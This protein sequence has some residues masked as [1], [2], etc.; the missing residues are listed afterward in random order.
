[1]GRH[2]RKGPAPKSSPRTDSSAPADA[3]QAAQPGP[4]TAHG[5][6]PGTDAAAYDAYDPGSGP[7]GAYGTGGQPGQ[8]PAGGYG[9]GGRPPVADGY[10]NGGSGYGA[11]AQSGGGRERGG[12]PAARY[13]AGGQPAP[14]YDAGGQPA[15][16]YDAGGQPAA[17]YGVGGQS[18]PGYHRS[19]HHPGDYGTGAHHSAPTGPGAFTT[20]Q[21]GQAGPAAPLGHGAEHTATGYGVPQARGG[22]PEQHEPG[23][24][25]G[26]GPGTAVPPHDPATAVPPHSGAP[27]GPLPRPSGPQAPPGAA[28]TGSRIPGP[29]REFVDAFDPSGAASGPGADSGT[30][31]LQGAEAPGDR[32]RDAAP[33]AVPDQRTPL[34]GTK[35]RT[36]TGIAA[37]AVTTVLAIIVAGQ[38]ATENE[39]REETGTTGDER[40]EDTGPASRSDSRTPPQPAVR[41]TKPQAPTYEQL[42]A[43]RFPIDR[44]FTGSGTFQAVPGFDKAPG[45][46][47]KIPYR[48]DVEKG[49]KMD[50]LLFATAVQR[51]LND[52]R[53]WAGNG[54]MAF[55]R[56]SSGDPAFVITLASPGT[57][58]V[59]C[60]KSGLNTS[61]DKVS[62]DSASTSRVMINAYRWGLGSETY[63]PGAMFAYRQMLINHEVGH[64]LGHGHVSCRTEGALA[65]VMQQQTK[66]L[67]IDDIRCRPNPWVHP[68]G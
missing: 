2:S 34:S 3:G 56:I 43:T 48:V 5:A 10:G 45:K 62:C 21:Q 40:A 8:Q 1:M 33:G 59:W 60:A 39:R 36:V 66:S 26:A 22:H 61:I 14:G 19:A 18:A 64:R 24:G 65:P 41:D 15:P 42:M 38:V 30:A 25:W 13:D 6:G 51:T 68:K 52:R 7:S 4:D 55:E 35:S 44:E 31:T 54:E 23:G 67:N 28:A 53:S 11:G 9:P 50:G 32:P 46:G 47:K 20:P 29:R 37:A 57:T 58:D 63:G 27:T 49:L 16:G 12:Q 17:G